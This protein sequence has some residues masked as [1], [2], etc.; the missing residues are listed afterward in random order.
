VLLGLRL[1]P[2]LPVEP[3]GAEVAVGAQRS[4]S[5]LLG[6]GQGLAVGG[7]GLLGFGRPML[8]EDLADEAERVRPVSP[9]SSSSKGGTTRTVA[10]PSSRTVRRRRDPKARTRPRNRGNSNSGR[11]MHPGFSVVRA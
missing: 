9:S 7:I 5:Q 11:R 6:Q 10:T 2:R 1:V 8:R 4:H 3:A